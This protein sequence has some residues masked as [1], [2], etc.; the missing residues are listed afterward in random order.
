MELKAC[1]P[2]LSFSAAVAVIK[3][4]HVGERLIRVALNADELAG[5]EQGGDGKGDRQNEVP[6]KRFGL[7]KPKSRDAAVG[8]VGI[9]IYQ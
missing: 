8:V 4:R 6:P 3:E 9:N 1:P 2:A 7:R 5:C